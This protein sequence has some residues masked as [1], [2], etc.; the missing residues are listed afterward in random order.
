MRRFIHILAMI[1]HVSGITVTMILGKPRI[2]VNGG[3]EIAHTRTLY[4]DHLLRRY[5]TQ[6]FFTFPFANKRKVW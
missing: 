6:T 3:S 2:Y 5:D 4:L 1:R